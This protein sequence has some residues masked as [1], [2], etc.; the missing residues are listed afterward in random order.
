MSEEYKAPKSKVKLFDRIFKPQVITIANG[1]TTV[2]PRSRMPLILIVLFVVIFWAFKMTDFSFATVF[3]RINELFVILG[4][5]FHPKWSFFGKVISPL[6]DTIKMSI[7]GTVIGCALALPFA[8]LASSNIIHSRVVVSFIRFILALIRTVPTLII[9]LV[10]ALIFSLGTFAGTLAIAIFTFGVVAKM[11][12]E[13]IE[14]I[15]MGPFEAMEA[16]GANKF[17][18]FWSACIPQILPVYLSHSLYCFEMN[19]RASAIL[20][21]VGAG[22]LGITINE[23]IGWRDYNGLGMVLL[24]LFVVVVAIEFFSEYLRKKLS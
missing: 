19:V 9:A 2:R 21:Y 11:L 1:H 16:L 8:V 13:S 5:I 23:R 18:A 4:K 12:Y 22:G 15:D 7:L 14:T 20:G 24:A 3:S 17:Q 6:I 10:C